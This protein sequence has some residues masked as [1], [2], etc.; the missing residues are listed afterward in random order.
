MSKDASRHNP[1][2]GC[3]PHLRCPFHPLLAGWLGMLGAIFMLHFGTFHLASLAWRQAGVNAMLLDAK[4]ING[5]RSPA[6]FWG[7]RWN[8]G[9]Q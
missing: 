4:S 2:L 5:Q 9:V 3:G 8:T 1:A 7:A 6:E